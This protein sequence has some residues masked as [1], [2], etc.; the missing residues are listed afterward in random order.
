AGV[1]TNAASAAPASF[2]SRICA[3]SDDSV[4]LQNALADDE[5]RKLGGVENF[6]GLASEQKALHAAAA[7]RGHDDQIA[8]LA[9]G[10]LD[11]TLCGRVVG[12][13]KSVRSEA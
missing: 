11:D 6:C 12:D 10:G 1:L 8:S 2:P 4:W 5:H 13:M 7:V 3:T 9:F